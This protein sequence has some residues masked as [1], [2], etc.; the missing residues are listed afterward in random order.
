LF[1]GSWW[2]WGDIDVVQSVRNMQC[3]IVMFL[4]PSYAQ[5]FHWWIEQNYH[6]NIRIREH[7]GT[8]ARVNI[9]AI[10]CQCGL[11]HLVWPRCLIEVHGKLGICV[12]GINFVSS[13]SGHSLFCC[14]AELLTWSPVLYPFSCQLLNFLTF[15]LHSLMLKHT[16]IWSNMLHF[17]LV[18][19]CL[20]FFL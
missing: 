17:Y 8:A 2:G 18:S 13:N 14:F 7:L 15:I 1:G 9:L 16:H 11:L 5:R 19:S 3:G 6:Y 10:N 12:Q 20:H 4:N